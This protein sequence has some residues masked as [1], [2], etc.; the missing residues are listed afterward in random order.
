MSQHGHHD[1]VVGGQVRGHLAHY[2]QMFVTP[3]Y[4]YGSV[5]FLFLLKKY[6][7]QYIEYIR[8]CAYSDPNNYPGNG[9]DVLLIK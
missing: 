9:V 1:G 7:Y 6:I 4:I 5:V 2:P 3:V 8:C